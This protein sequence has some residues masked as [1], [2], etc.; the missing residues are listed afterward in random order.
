MG[1]R[2]LT[3]LRLLGAFERIR[4]L[5][6]GRTHPGSG[7]AEEDCMERAL[8]SATEGFDLPVALGFDLG[9]T[10]PMFTLPIGVRASVDFDAE[11]TLGLL[12]SGVEAD[13]RIP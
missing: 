8:C 13:S 11:P 4:A 7:F 10:D 9:H 5:V 2:Y 3:R 1:R 12:G 6:V